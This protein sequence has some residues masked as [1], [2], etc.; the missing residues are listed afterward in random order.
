M[1]AFTS[2]LKKAYCELAE[3][4]YLESNVEPSIRITAD[5]VHVIFPLSKL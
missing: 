2:S 5:G 1:D 3:S 4:Y